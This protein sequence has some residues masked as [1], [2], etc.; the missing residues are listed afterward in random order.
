MIPSVVASE[1][2]VALHDFLKTGFG[3]S[4]PELSGVV[5]DFLADPDNLVKGPYL[6]I[7]LPF[8]HVAEGGEPFPHIPLGFTPYTHQHA[9]MERLSPDAGR[10]TV[11]ATGTG[12]GK[13]ECFLYPVLEHCRRQAGKKGIKAVVVYPMNAL[14]SDQARRI[15]RI[16]HDTPSL[17]GKVT[18]GLFIGQTGG[19]PRDR[20]GP[21]AVVTDRSAMREHPP[22]ILLTNYKMLDYLMIRPRDRR[23]WRHN[24][25]DTLRYL[26][27]DELHTFDGAQGTDLACLIR[28]LRMRLGTPAE[29]LVC[30]GTSATLGGDPREYASR[31]FDQEFDA[32]SIVGE[33]RQTIDA[34]LGDAFIRHHL[35][36]TQDLAKVVDAR[37]YDTAEA[38]L[39]AQHE[40]FLGTPIE[41]DFEAPDWRVALGEGLRQHV[42]FRNLLQALKGRPKSLP[43]LAKRLQGTLP[44]ANDKEALGVL[45]GLCALI[46]AA[47]RRPA[48]SDDGGDALLPFLH[49]GVHLWVRE[50]RRMVCS[51]GSENAG[52]KDA[53]DGNLDDSSLDDSSNL[54]DGSLDDQNGS[55]F[56]LRHSADL[57]ADE[58]FVHLPLVQC[59]ECHVTGWVTKLSGVGSARPKVLSHRARGGAQDGL[60]DIYGAFFGGDVD[61]VFLFPRDGAGSA[62]AGA[63]DPG[64]ASNGAEPRQGART[65][66]RTPDPGKGVPSLL[67]GKCGVLA[68]DDGDRADS[69]QPDA[70]CACPDSALVKVYR[71]VV[72]TP[73]GGSSGRG[74]P[75]LSKA[76]PYC[77]ARDAMVILGARAASLLAVALNQTVSS[78]HNDDPKVIAFSDSVQDAAHRAGFVS[79]RT[80]STNMRAAIAQTVAENNGSSLEELS[81]QVATHWRNRWQNASGN[82]HDTLDPPSDAPDLAR[83]VGEFIAPDRRWLNEFRQLEE[84]GRLPRNSDLPELV[85][86][87]MRWDTFAEFG[88]RSA[89]GR[90][91][92]NTRA[93]AVGVER[94][95]LDEACETATDR[96][97][98]ELEGMRTALDEVARALVLGIVRRMK[99]RGAILTDL[100]AKYL[101]D[102]GN[103]HLL[104]INPAL[105]DVGTDRSTVPVFPG[106]K[107]TRKSGVEALYGS[108][109]RGWSWYQKWTRKV[110]D[111]ADL[112]LVVHDSDVV[113]NTVFRAMDA[114]GLVRQAD[115]GKGQHA[116]GLAPDRLYVTTEVAEV[117]SGTGRPLVVARQEAKLW[118]G[119][120]SLDL[121]APDR[122]GPPEVARPT[123]FGRLYRDMKVR[124][125]VAAEHTALLPRKERELLEER[126]A[127][128]GYR[129]W[130]PNILSATPT[131]ELGIDIGD[132]STV[133]LC[134]VPP[135]PANY[136][137]RTG[138]AGRRDGNAFNLALAAAQ[139][140]DLYFYEQPMDMLAGKV[141]PPGVFLN[142]TA[143]LERQ[144]IAYCFDS[145]VASGVDERAVPRTMREVLA[146][147][148]R[149]RLS[150]F[151]YPFFDF[152]GEHAGELA[153]SFL[154]A[155]D[156]DLSD[157]SKRAL[158][159]FVLGDDADSP[160]H[161]QPLVHRLLNRFAEVARERKSIRREVQALQ[162]RAGAMGRGPQDESTQAEIDE[163]NAERRGLQGV[164]RKIDNR[165]TYN[166]L[167]DEGLVPNYAFPEKGVLLRSVILRS[168]GRTARSDR[169]PDPRSDHEV[170][171]Y[172]R[173]AAA[174]LSE[175][176]P[177]NSFY[178]GARKVQID[179]VDLE[180]SKLEQWRLCPACVYCERVDSVDDHATC[181]RCGDPRWGD[182]GQR[183]EMLPLRMVHATTSDKRSRIGDESDQR[184][185]RF[186]TRHLV[187]DF[188][189]DKARTAFVATGTPFGFE[190]IQ[191]ATFREMNFGHHADQ[192]E[193]TLVAGMELPR[194]G[195]RICRR[196]GKVQPPSADSDATE[197]TRT[198]PAGRR[199]GGGSSTDTTAE[200]IYLYREFES[201]A[202]RMLV[203]GVG[204]ASA[205]LN[206]H[207]FVAALELGLRRKFGGEIGHLRTMECE[208][209]IPETSRNRKYLLLYDTV[210]GGTGYLKDRMTAPDKLRSI[211]EAALAALR[212]CACIEDPEKD[213]CYRCVFAYR[214]SRDLPTTSRKV[215]EQLVAATLKRWSEL[216]VVEGLTGVSANVLTESELEERF[217]E[218][219]RQKAANPSADGSGSA[220]GP[221]LAS[222]SRLAVG[223]RPA[224][225]DGSADAPAVEI[226]SAQVRG[227]PGYALSVGGNKYL[228]EP[229]VDFDLGDGVAVPSRPDFVIWPDSAHGAGALRGAGLPESAEGSQA[230]AL[231]QDTPAIAV[232]LDGFAYHR[233]Q[234]GDDSAKRM[235]LARAGF[236]VW[237]LTWDDLE[238]AFGGVPSAPNFLGD[239]GTTQTAVQYALDDRWD[240]QWNTR[241]LRSRLGAP[242][243]DLLLHYLA[244]PDP[245]K[246]R[247][248]VFVEL[249]GVFDQDQMATPALRARFDEAAGDALPGQALETVADLPQPVVVGGFGLWVAGTA[250]GP[251]RATPGSAAT[252]GHTATPGALRP[253]A[254]LFAALPHAAVREPDPAGVI[255]VAHFDDEHT[256]AG[257][258]A[259]ADAPDADA[260]DAPARSNA[261]NAMTKQYRSD[262][263]GVLRLFNILQFLPQ[264]WWTTRTG[265]SGG[266]Y[267]E[268][269]PTDALHGRDA[270][271]LEDDIRRLVAR[272]LRPLL[273][274]LAQRDLPAPEP[275]H[276][277]VD[278]AGKV[279][280]HAELAWPSR[281]VAVLLPDPEHHR[282][283]YERSGWQVLTADP[284]G[285][286]GAFVDTL[287]QALADPPQP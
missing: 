72:V 194:G 213:G 10:S 47:R 31:I 275:G 151:P 122:Y 219:L 156:K 57:K 202:I 167:T 48:P 180:T 217:I 5:D 197:H 114:S 177:E 259:N 1:A 136:M 99:D 138:R 280:A 124:R 113:L 50:L 34:F 250:N 90:T 96:L 121:L 118:H 206:M 20:M 56:R 44:V 272:E 67:C 13:T 59:R 226:R 266:L 45:N 95:T 218:A 268:F 199:R 41:G 205:D 188:D 54:G 227:K 169:K 241:Q 255:A 236:L 105:P 282:M 63:G 107:A 195:F 135:E 221:G 85:E 193:P 172:E 212:E 35:L 82:P 187:A 215:A 178:A 185:P 198:C 149:R 117:R 239:H 154:A 166:F 208:Y 263:N 4:N 69:S 16:V 262:W 36:P 279:V 267:P 271:S 269:A 119:V 58:P 216:E 240:A 64:T 24:E 158:S 89:I 42:V 254:S 278:K 133:M 238:G 83:F 15:A 190:Y 277:L 62:G 246:W 176:A 55:R 86:Q 147:V 181:P 252:P 210:P 75:R 270:E 174:A 51:V 146:N 38:Y 253:A 257:A 229:Q 211:F 251:S 189:P 137:Q 225:G 126:F 165:E 232:F 100:V 161:G 71:P 81:K 242:S 65:P 32:D 104:R 143:V 26:V 125:I 17:R 68:N 92:E 164:L 108:G 88:Q 116:W 256:D 91:L 97:R 49:V 258:E 129:P 127:A 148:E 110:L 39:R 9:A 145:W 21:D 142:A 231:S 228:L 235:C 204:G 203:P 160:L 243:F 286:A 101:A 230:S 70:I 273:R 8:E 183:R 103:A 159:R 157:A 162:R 80:W 43:E 46:S 33:T 182:V 53:G 153:A 249:L 223:S 66:A 155:F 123:W 2:L 234:T 78:R 276:E 22:D 28:R 247:R 73:R 134:S 192:T 141:E 285:L 201:E 152:V 106:T 260:P 23:L 281:R 79:A 191:S 245:A 163:V 184:Q 25:P 120:P 244:N 37:R 98:E 7:S 170:F 248:A 84:T 93:A 264:A 139:P 224:S 18:A 171:E 140:H 233:D 109:G 287:A 115:I 196:C 27:V 131:L 274:Q 175:L 186:Y 30:A 261:Q 3:P 61:A 52:G 112:A 179:R 111:H 173:P 284:E 168:G 130:S 12:S 200:C 132:L 11:V 150:R 76:C 94:A 207:S 87:R 14:A 128:E 6:S 209:P 222:G 144:M 237:S 283:H 214:R 220:A 19:S 29:K 102:G 77:N 74:K 40:L 60:R 265:V